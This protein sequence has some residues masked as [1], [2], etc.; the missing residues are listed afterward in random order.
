KPTGYHSAPTPPLTTSPAM[1][2]NDAADRYSPDTAA[3]LNAGEIRREA[4]RKSYVVRI[5]ATPR[6]PMSRVASSTGTTA[7]AITGGPRPRPA[8]LGATATRPAPP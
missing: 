7:K 8:R 4:A 1:P 2:R 6:A 5:A 3:A